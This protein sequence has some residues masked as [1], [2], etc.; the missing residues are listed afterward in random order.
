MKTASFSTCGGTSA[1]SG[2]NTAATG[3]QR[4]L[5]RLECGFALRAAARRASGPEAWLLCGVATTTASSSSSSPATRTARPS[6]AWSSTSRASG[7]DK[8]S[9][10]S[11]ATASRRCQRTAGCGASC[12]PC[13]HLQRQASCVRESGRASWRRKC[14]RPRRR[15]EGAACA[16]SQEAS[17]GAGQ[18][19]T[20]RALLTALQHTCEAGRASECTV[21]KHA[22]ARIA[23][24][25]FPATPALR[26]RWALDASFKAR[27]PINAAK[28]G[29][30]CE[31]RL[32]AEHR[33]AGSSSASSSHVRRPS[34]FALHIRWGSSPLASLAARW[35]S[36]PKS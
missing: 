34:G 2:R 3:G 23:P 7:D 12:R 36:S 35:F 27:A 31:F 33:V 15:L 11:R 29:C 26:P 22:R 21:N 10:F 1:T 18:Q 25:S 17:F 14:R 8:N 20:A 13:A 19:R 30:V 4:S 32:T 28:V 16:R 9:L 6:H 24:A 5:Q